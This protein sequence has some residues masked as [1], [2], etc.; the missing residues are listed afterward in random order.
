MSRLQELAT[1]Y[2]YDQLPYNHGVR[3]DY[4]CNFPSAPPKMDRRRDRNIVWGLV[5]AGVI[6]MTCFIGA[7]VAFT[8]IF[9]VKTRN[10]G[11][12]TTDSPEYTL[13]KNTRFKECYDISASA[14]T[15]C[16]AIRVTLNDTSIPGFQEHNVGYLGSD[17]LFDNQKGSDITWDWC[18]VISCF[19]DYKV[20][21]STARDSAIWPTLLTSW[22]AVAT[23]ILGSLFQF[24][25]LQ[26]ALY[27]SKK[28]PCKGIGEVGWFSWLLVLFDLGSFVWWWVGF[29]KL[30]AAPASAATPFITGWVIP[31]KYAS[32]LNYHPYSC[33]FRKNPRGQKIA[34][35]I[36]YGLAALQWI[37]SLYI[38]HVNFPPGISSRWGL[39]APNPSY[40]CVTSQI[41]ASPGASTCSAEQICSRNWLFID[42]G[43]EPTY[44]H[45]GPIL[46]IGIV[47]IVLTLV[48]L[49]PVLMAVFSIFMNLVTGEKDISMSPRNT[50]RW[51]DIGPAAFVSFTAIFEI[52]VGC[53]LVDDFVK[54]L[55]VISP[56]AAVTFDWECQVIHVALSPWRYYIDVDYDKGLRLVKMWFNS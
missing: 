43:Y 25:L 54:R 49:F 13:Y 11:G 3:G 8:V 53:I 55:R 14:T 15:N 47:F 6:L 34:R 24:G 36:L 17:K 19:E 4:D 46:A 9:A 32:S 27:S 18:E 20:I 31:W 7:A 45:Q 10:I 48:A 16:S 52:I 5:S 12:Y 39:R 41:D 28:K 35:G 38:W 22:G 23:F 29:G 33:A 2:Q 50:L 26:K 40:D 44:Q 21:P 1:G 51:A 30:A 56:N 37:A 42:P